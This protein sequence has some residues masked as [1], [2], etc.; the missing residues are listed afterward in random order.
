MKP[1]KKIVALGLSGALL[2]A[3]PMNAAAEAKK[4]ENMDEATWIR[5][6]D[7][8]LEYDEIRDLVENY[9]PTYLQVVGNIE[10]NTVTFLEA[11]K[12]LRNYADTMAADAKEIKDDNP[13]LYQAIQGAADGYRKGAKKY[14]DAVDSVH[15]KSR[16]SLRQ[17]R[18][19]VASGVQMAVIGYYQAQA[20]LEMVETAAELSQAAYDSAVTQQTLGMATSTDVQAAEKAL[21]SAQGQ[22]KNIQDSMT[23]V[24]QQICNMTG[25]A[26]NADMQLGEVPQPDLARIDTMNPEN[27]LFRAIGNNYTLIEQRSMSGKGDSNR[28]AKFRLIDETE[29]KVKIELETLYQSILEGRTAYEAAGTAFQSAQITMNGNDLKYQMGMLGRLE[30]LQAKMA[31]LQQKAA[32]R[33]AALSLRQAMENYDWAVAGLADVK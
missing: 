10:A 23:K 29:A 19:S 3:V 31:Y 2:F 22:L 24:R 32:Y 6:Q 28:N 14:E 18:D 25:W 11:A 26:Y 9:N 13:F 30:Y 1:C 21:Q 4:P 33:T 17:V 12:E 8:V 7:N 5:L 20:S 15:N 27:D 16:N